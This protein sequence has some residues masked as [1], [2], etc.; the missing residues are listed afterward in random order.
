M[1]HSLCCP[2]RMSISFQTWSHFLPLA[3]TSCLCKRSNPRSL[4]ADCSVLLKRP[5]IPP[6]SSLPYS[7]CCSSLDTPKAGLPET[8]D[9]LS[10][11]S[12]TSEG[13]SWHQICVHE[14]TNRHP[15]RKHHSQ[16]LRTEFFRGHQKGCELLCIL[17]SQA[18]LW[19]K[20]KEA[21]TKVIHDTNGS[22]TT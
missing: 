5:Q 19:W 10:L 2:K 14:L 8:S 17:A 22:P 13:N 6:L 3:R 18:I 11:H 16:G 1:L 12:N 21:S 15:Q 7:I 9:L 4:L 20:D